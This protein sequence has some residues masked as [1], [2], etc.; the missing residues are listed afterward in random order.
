SFLGPNSLTVIANAGQAQIKGAEA[1]LNWRVTDHL[2]F[3]TS[4][5]YTDAYLTQPYCKDPADCP[6][7][8]QAPSGQM[9]PITPKFKGDATARYDFNVD[10]F[11]AHVQGAINYQTSS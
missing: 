8:L 2:T 10:E 4:G 7:T 1:T 9:L 5:T 3:N 6:G 11:A